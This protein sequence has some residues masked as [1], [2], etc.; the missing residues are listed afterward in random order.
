MT[1]S[2]TG[3]QT[4]PDGAAPVPS[5]GFRPRLFGP[6]NLAVAN[7]TS[8]AALVAI[9][10][11]HDLHARQIAAALPTVA[12]ELK[13]FYESNFSRTLAMIDAMRAGKLPTQL[14]FSLSALALHGYEP[15]QLRTAPDG[16]L[17]ATTWSAGVH[18]LTK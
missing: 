1:H 6:T 4:P 13:S 8:I 9:L 7:R 15:I 5:G 11:R 18:L 14:I 16:S 2:D 17:L 3:G 10:T 12:T